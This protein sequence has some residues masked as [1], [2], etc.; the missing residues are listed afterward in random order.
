M[1]G[2]RTTVQLPPAKT[3]VEKPSEAAP[4]PKSSKPLPGATEKQDQF[5]EL[6][7]RLHRKLVDQI[8]MTRMVGDENELRA[9]VREIVEKLCEQENTL[10]NFNERQRLISEV[11]DETFGLGPLEV[12]LADTTISDILINGPKQIY[13]ERSG[14]IE[15]TDVKF[16]DNG[17]LMHVIDK[18]VSQ[19]GRRCDE[20]SPM[21]D[22]RLPDGSR[23]NAVIPPLAIDG[24]S[25]SIRRFGADP[26]TWD[27]YIRFRSCTPEIRDFL[28]ACVLA[29]LNIIILG[30]TGSG[31][32]TLLNNLSSFIPPEDRIV[33]MEDAAELRLRQPHVV[34]LESRPPNIEGK[35][36]ISIRDLLVNSLRMRPDRIVV[37]ECRGAET[38]D[39]LQAMNT[40][41]DGSLTTIHANSARDAVQRVETMVMMA[42][43][44]LP[45]RAIRQQFASAIHLLVQAQRLSGGPRKIVS[46]TEVQGMEGDTITMQDIFKFEQ[47]GVT[48]SGKAYGQLVSTGLRPGF[49]DRLKSSGC[50][51]DPA[52]FERRVLMRDEQD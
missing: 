27:D 18:I 49:L 12:L 9:Q 45:L 44:E 39:M 51:I 11:L 41:H 6:K 26:L 3:K 15:L 40:G 8:D 21:V 1:F 2:K 4:A 31:K 38:L 22:A 14:R 25:M 17:H 33:T 43:F 47:L 34:R 37:G 13:V 46:V 50:T 19:V 30:G 28:Q 7:Q 32:T 29:H 48:A 20:T 36:Q 52:I 24:P 5:S 16:R 23:V 42:G 10:L 35:G